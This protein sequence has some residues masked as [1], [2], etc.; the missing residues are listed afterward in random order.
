[1]SKTPKQNITPLMCFAYNFSDMS[2]EV[3]FHVNKNTKVPYCV[4]CS[5]SAVIYVINNGSSFCACAADMQGR[6]L[7]C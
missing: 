2:T 5:N 1:M 4:T 7:R 6:T 3:Q